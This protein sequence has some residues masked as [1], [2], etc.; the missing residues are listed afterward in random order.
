VDDDPCVRRA[1]HNTLQ[2][3]GFIACE[4]LDGE[5]ALRKVSEAPC[6]VVLLDINMPGLG[7]IE[8]CRQLRRLLPQIAIFMLTVRNEEEDKVRALEAGADDYV[9]KPLSIPELTARVRAAI[10]RAQNLRDIEKTVLRIGDVE[11]DPT[12]RAVHKAGN[13][14]H[15]TP[16]EFDLL[17]YLMAHAGRPITHGRLLAAVW[18]PE[19]MDEVEYLRTYV[20]QLRKKIEDDPEVPKYL[21]TNT[22]IGYRFRENDLPDGRPSPCTR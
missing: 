10:R 13:F 15:L 20:R 11:L 6:D 16:K 18:G 7:G 4:A 1:L 5:Q 14:I 21:L 19:Q 12:R 2:T 22:Q 8:T 3:L 9:T 17:H